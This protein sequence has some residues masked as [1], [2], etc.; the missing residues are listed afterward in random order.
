MTKE[1]IE[2]FENW[3]KFSNRLGSNKQHMRVSPRRSGSEFLESSNQG[4]RVHRGTFCNK[5][6]L[7]L[8]NLKLGLS[9]LR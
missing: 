4:Q 5:E 7:T 3:Q 2:H 8:R 1:L 9:T 6:L